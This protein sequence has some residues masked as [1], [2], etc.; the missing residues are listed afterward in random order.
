[1]QRK[2]APKMKREFHTVDK[3]FHGYN[4]NWQ[5]PPFTDSVFVAQAQAAFER[6]NS[7]LDLLKNV[8]AESAQ[9]QPK[10]FHSLVEIQVVVQGSKT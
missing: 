3:L 1:M 7:G 4:G 6:I 10:E 5:M 9:I 2:G 8:I